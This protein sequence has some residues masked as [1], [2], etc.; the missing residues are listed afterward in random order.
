MQEFR[1]GVQDALS[2]LDAARAEPLPDPAPVDSPASS[3]AGHR[4][5]TGPRV[6]SEVLE[7]LALTV[8]EVRQAL[9]ELR[10][11]HELSD[12]ESD[13]ENESDGHQVASSPEVYGARLI[14]LNMALNGAPRAETERYLHRNFSLPDGAKIAADAYRRAPRPDDA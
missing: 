6:S 2:W 4:K 10:A 9:A 8:G 5:R 1:A 11:V 13:G 12:G 14:A 7:Q 3:D